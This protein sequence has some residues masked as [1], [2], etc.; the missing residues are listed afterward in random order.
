ML[1]QHS[2]FCSTPSLFIPLLKQRKPFLHHLSFPR[3]TKSSI[4][5][6]S[7]LGPG[8]FDDIVQI[9]HNKILIAAGV[10]VAI[11]QLSKP[12]TSVILY[13]KEFDIRAIVQAGGFPSSHSS[14]TVASAT[15]FGLERGFS[16][17]IFGLAV[18]YAGLIMYD[19]QGVRREV[20]I[21]ARTLNKLLLQMQANS[22]HSKDKDKDNLF[23]SQSGLSNPLKVEEFEKSLLSQEATL[24]PQ[25]ANGG[26]LVK[27]GSKIRQTEAEETSK[28]AVDGIPPLKESIGHTE[29]EVIVGALVGFLVALAVYNIM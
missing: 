8:L 22:L 5:R 19:A 21:H 23:N 1:L 26:L 2:M 17:P 16:D 12:F 27:S 18:V 3:K 15:L 9:A 25:Q 10:S 24:E 7:S 4:V 13:G 28:L 29:I 6:V 11:G 20:G 14:A